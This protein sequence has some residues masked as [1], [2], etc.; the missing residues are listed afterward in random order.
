ML[1]QAQSSCPQGMG[2][3]PPVLLAM[4]SSKT[5]PLE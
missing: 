5:A 4:T 1:A 2:S 3:A